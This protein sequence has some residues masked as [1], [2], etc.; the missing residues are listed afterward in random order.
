MDSPSNSPST[1]TR[2]NS[3][4]AAGGKRQHWGIGMILFVV[5]GQAQ[6]A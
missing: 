1:Q 4:V 5:S 2:N 6:E 3:T